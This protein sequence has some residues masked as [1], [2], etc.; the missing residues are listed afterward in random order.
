MQEVDEFER[1]W[2]ICE[3]VFG[4]VLQ[5]DD[6]AHGLQAQEGRQLVDV[7]KVDHRQLGHVHHDGHAV[8]AV[9]EYWRVVH[10]TKMAA[11]RVALVL[12]AVESVRVVGI[13]DKYTAVDRLIIAALL[14]PTMASSID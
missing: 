10:R 6:A 1:K 7:D 4:E 5:N 8:A 3:L 14:L 13:E 11:A 9:R 12:D 2:K